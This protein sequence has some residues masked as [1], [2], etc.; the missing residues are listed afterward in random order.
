MKIE[1]NPNYVLRV[2]SNNDFRMLIIPR[3]MRLPSERIVCGLHLNRVVQ[4][5]NPFPKNRKITLDGNWR[6]RR[7]GATGATGARARQGNKQNVLC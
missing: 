5:I 3:R 7:K 6:W 4:S 1:R 2:L